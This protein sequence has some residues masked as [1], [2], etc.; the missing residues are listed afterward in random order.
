MQD[1]GLRVVRTWAFY[2]GTPDDYHSMQPY[3]G[4]FNE[5]TLEALD[6]VIAQAASHG[7]RVILA[8]VNYW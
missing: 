1:L 4:V 2:D 5:H 7:M 3:P 8:L 6:F